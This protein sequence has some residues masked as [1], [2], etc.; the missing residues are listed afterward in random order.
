MSITVD[1]TPT[2]YLFR[3][4]KERGLNPCN[5]IS[6]TSTDSRKSYER[7]FVVR[8]PNGGP[9]QQLESLSI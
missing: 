9:Q 5:S 3:T 8:V 4:R 6:I 2:S 1:G 7:I